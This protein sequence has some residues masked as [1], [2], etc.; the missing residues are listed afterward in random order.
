MDLLAILFL[1]FGGVVVLGLLLLAIA[2]AFA[3]FGAMTM[4]EDINDDN[5]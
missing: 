2:S 3:F 4:P 1:V 5:F